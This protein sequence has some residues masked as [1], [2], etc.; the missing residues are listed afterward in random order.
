LSGLSPQTRIVGQA[1]L[2][3]NKYMKEEKFLRPMGVDTH[4]KTGLDF[5]KGVELFV[6]I[7]TL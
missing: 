2:A 4:P 3:N 5:D 1:V 7:R 6:D